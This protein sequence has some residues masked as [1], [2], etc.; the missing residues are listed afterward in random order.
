MGD[1]PEAHSQ[2]GCRCFANDRDISASFR[3]RWQ[4][5]EIVCTADPRW[6]ER[7]DLVALTMNWLDPDEFDD[8]F[9][10]REFFTRSIE[11]FG[12]L[13]MSF[14]THGLPDTIAASEAIM[15]HPAA[16]RD[17]GRHAARAL[18]LDCAIIDRLTQ[19]GIRN[20]QTGRRYLDLNAFE[21]SQYILP[22]ML[23]IQNYDRAFAV[24]AIECIMSLHEHRVRSY[25]D[26]CDMDDVLEG[27]L[28]ATGLIQDGQLCL[29]VLQLLWHMDVYHHT[30]SFSRLLKTSLNLLPCRDVVKALSPVMSGEDLAVH[31][32]E[33]CVLEGLRW[34]AA[35]EDVLLDLLNPCH[36]LT[37][38]MSSAAL[39]P[40]NHLCCI[41]CARSV[42]QRVPF[43][44]VLYARRDPAATAAE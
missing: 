23:M 5:E 12:F 34:S 19:A 30:D 2:C 25:S 22:S 44:L 35:T 36:Y 16:I 21:I 9:L 15:T 27:L 4:L 11:I 20:L 32:P 31:I 39:Y 38:H 8:V 3:K 28:Q 18:T 29:A 37:M 10:D 17:F 43:I 13:P 33:V 6:R 14:K 26:D 40:A 7:D 1:N 42:Y 41:V 24:R